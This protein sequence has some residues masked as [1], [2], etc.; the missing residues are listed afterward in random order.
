MGKKSDEAS[1]YKVE[2]E[3]DE[4]SENE[5]TTQAETEID[6][7][8]R[9]DDLP[10]EK[11]NVF[12]RFCHWYS[13]HKK[14][15]LPLTLLLVLGILWA[16]PA[17]R[18]PI[19]GTFMKQQ[20]AVQVI[21]AGT[22]KPVTSATVLLDGQKIQTDTKGKAILKVPVGHAV[23]EVSKNYYKKTSQNVL[24]P[25]LRQKNAQ[26]ISIQATGR[27][28]EIMV[29][30]KITGKP[31]E[32]AVV[33]AA[34]AEAKTDKNGQAVLVVSPDRTKL[35][36]S[37]SSKGYNNI[38]GDVEVNAAKAGINTFNLVPSGKLYFLSNKS[39]K[40]DVVKSD[41]DGNA[42]QTVLVGTGKE[43]K[44]NTVMLAS[45][46]WR[47][48][49]LHSKR[50]GS[51][52]AKLFL[53][54]TTNDQLTVM[55]E[56]NADFSLVGWS[57]HKFVYKVNR[58][59]YMAWQSGGT[60]LK[61]YDAPAKKII[62]IDQSEGEGN[63]SYDFANEDL[64]QVYILPDDELFYA[65]D[66]TFGN[67]G[68]QNGVKKAGLY[69][70]KADGTGKKTV[71]SYARPSYPDQYG[72]TLNLRPYGPEG[73]YVATQFTKPEQFF[74]YE[75]GKL[76]PTTEITQESFYESYPTYLIS[77]SGKRTFW[78]ESRDGK[79]LLFVGDDEG[80]N[81]KQL[82]TPDDYLVYGWYTEDYL[83]VSKKG[84]ELYIM[85]VNGGAPVK[86]TDYYKP[87]R[88]FYGY[89]SGYGGL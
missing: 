65:K 68:A 2:T 49:A 53:I 37:I 6:S 17:T 55:D 80:K 5:S 24:V 51:E 61:S 47:Y 27:Q 77:P 4:L 86:M 52:H 83:L 46:D 38:T 73:A 40:I 87:E 67:I 82:G 62:K 26:T 58:T 12:G 3:L 66:L 72:L 50:D 79:S 29:L 32:G 54:D 74:E 28:V 57:N 44:N 16:V 42:R 88:S 89:G 8:Q 23:L 34:N 78:S 81:G 13:T 84:S 18:Y 45:R 21:D 19:A 31:L 25:I 7:K 35:S 48:L 60:V 56:G 36:V 71:K 59:G 15:S 30:H 63:T 85:S 14:L 1:D 69:S 39:G 64:S 10:T 76:T 43:E 20:Y 22:Q 33:S 41:L 9:S 75:H 70:V 11:K